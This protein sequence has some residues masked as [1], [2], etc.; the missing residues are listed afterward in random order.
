LRAGNKDYLVGGRDLPEIPLMTMKILI[1]HL[2][3][4]N[5]DVLIEGATPASVR[6]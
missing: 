1:V 5:N 6:I 2:D 3:V 4:T